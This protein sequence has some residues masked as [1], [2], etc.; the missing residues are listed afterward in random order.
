MKIITNLYLANAK[1]FLRERM[2]LF[3]IMLMPV[4]LAVFFGLIFGNTDSGFTLQ[5]GLVNEDVG[6]AG[7]Q[8][9]EGLTAEATDGVLNP[10]VGA[11]A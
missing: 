10:H 9:V 4:T 7:E 1:E 5:L 11:R 6:P 8:F 3:I 2:S